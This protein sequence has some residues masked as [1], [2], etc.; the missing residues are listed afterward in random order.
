MI[1]VLIVDDSAVARELIEHVLEADPEIVVIGCARNGAEALAVLEHKRPDVITMDVHMPGI[2]GFET[3]YRIMTEHPV[4]VIIVTA[5]LDPQTDSANFR[6]LEAGALAILPKPPGVGHRDHARAAAELVQTV[7]LMSEVR[8]VRRTF[9]PA[10]SLLQQPP[11]KAALPAPIKVVAIGASTGGPIVIQSILAS[12]PVGFPV[13]LLVVQHMADEFIR[14]FSD[15]LAGSCNIE[16]KVAVQGEFLRPGTAYVAP[17][18]LDMGI[19]GQ[20]RVTLTGG[21]AG[22]HLCPSVSHL[23][24]NIAERYGG[25]AVGILLSGMGSDG[26]PGLKEMKDRGALTIA[27]DEDSCVIFGMPAEAVKLKAAQH[28]LPPDG[29]IAMLLA[30]VKR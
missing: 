12:L 16:V 8:V 27:Q 19:D 26:A 28:V 1:K 7:K 21:K 10:K 9:R 29:I 5:S 25:H 23:F 3:T 14:G 4:P 30:V 15:W 22:Q 11:V 2:D 6:A 18:G 20:G 17:G 24:Y 13:P